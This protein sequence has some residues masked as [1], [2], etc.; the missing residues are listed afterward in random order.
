LVL[1]YVFDPLSS[2]RTF[3]SPSIKESGYR[4]GS[5]NSSQF[6]IVASK[7]SWNSFV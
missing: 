5:A 7:S 3:Y 6:Y 2:D 1:C 4:G